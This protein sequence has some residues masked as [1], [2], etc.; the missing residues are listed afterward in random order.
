MPDEQKQGI[1][2]QKMAEHLVPAKWNSIEGVLTALGLGIG[3]LVLLYFGLP[4]AGTILSGAAATVTG[5]AGLSFALVKLILGGTA[6]VALFMGV[7]S[8]TFRTSLRRTFLAAAFRY[9]RW[10]IMRDPVAMLKMAVDEQY[11][12]YQRGQQAVIRFQGS[13]QRQYAKIQE[14]NQRHEELIAKALMLKRQSEQVRE[15]NVKQNLL[16]QA[17]LMAEKAAGIKEDVD[18]FLVPDYEADRVMAQKLDK[19]VQAAELRVGR[20]KNTTERY[21]NKYNAVKDRRAA[22]G[23]LSAVL[24]ESDSQAL[25][26]DSMSE[27]ERQFALDLAE[28][29]QFDSAI[30]GVVAEMDADRAIA[31]EKGLDY[32]NKLEAQGGLAGLKSKIET[33]AVPQMNWGEVPSDLIANKNQPQVAARTR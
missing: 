33:Q 32:L 25:F 21:E 31:R 14:M 6:A 20:M 3:A 8:Q 4:I 9:R 29:A 15:P 2:F 24:G 19:A 23:E 17:I 10:Q 1:D 26:A 30:S 18:K 5:L 7:T 22:R 27:L 13:V 16:N 11:A 12:I 28:G